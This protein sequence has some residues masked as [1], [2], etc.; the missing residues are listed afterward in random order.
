[1]TL[2][3]NP[4]NFFAETEQ[5]AFH[6]GHLVRGIEV[7]RRSAAAGPAVQLPRHAAHAA[8]RP[9]LLADPDQPAARRR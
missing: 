9:E 7:D 6:A 4:T 8:R 5:V 3:R 2:N 1:M